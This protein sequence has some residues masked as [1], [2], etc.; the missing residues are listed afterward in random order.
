MFFPENLK[1]SKDHEW[2]RIEGNEAIVGI[3]DYA[4][5]ELGD[6]V[7]IDVSTVGKNLEKSRVFGSIEA[8]KIVSDLLMPISGKVIEVNSELEDHPELINSD[9][10]EK[11]WI[12]KIEILEVNQFDELLG[13]DAYR[14]FIGVL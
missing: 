4:Q 14:K 7:F 1:Y 6:I 11:G 9:P 2:V 10:Y 3:S 13:V 8:V 12:I 5:S